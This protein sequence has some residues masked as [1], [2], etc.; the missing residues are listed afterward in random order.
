MPPRFFGADRQGF[1][2]KVRKANPESSTYLQDIDNLDLRRVLVDLACKDGQGRNG[3]DRFNTRITHSHMP[4]APGIG[5]ELV[6]KI[7]PTDTLDHRVCAVTWWEKSGKWL[8]RNDANHPLD[9]TTLNVII[10]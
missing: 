6:L 4:F 9:C 8:L 5:Y 1:M 3:T 10:I 7:L 2:E